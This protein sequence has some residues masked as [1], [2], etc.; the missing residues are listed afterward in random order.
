MPTRKRHQYENENIMGEQ[1]VS[2]LADKEDMQQ[3]VR[4]LL[5]DV[6]ALDYMLKNDWFESDIIRIGAEQ[7]MCLVDSR[8]F[9]PA[10]IA[11]EALAKMQDLPWV[12]TELAR[13]NLETGATPVQFTGDCLNVMEQQIS[14]QLATIQERI[15]D[16]GADIILTGI[17]PTLQ[18]FDMGM[19]NLTPVPRYFALMKA[20]NQ[21]L[22]KRST[23]EVRLQGVD[24]LI[25]EH[26]SPLIE[27]CN[28]SFQVHLQVPPKKFVQM[29]N[30]A[31][32]ITAPVMAISANSPIVF[33]KRLW[34]ESRIALFQQAL[35]TRS[36]SDHMRER[37]PRV[38]FGNDWLHDSMIEIYKEDI[39]RFRVLISGD[40]KE[41]SF[42]LIKQGKVP[43]LRALQVHNSTVYRW[44]R[45]CYGISENG[46]PHL[47]IENRVF[48]AGP[49]IQDE[50]ANAAFW[51]GLMMAFAEEYED[52][53]Q[54]ISFE[55]AKDNFGKAAK[56]GIDTK[57]TWLNDE[58]ISA[59]LLVQQ[60]LLP[61]ARKGLEMMKVSPKDIDKYLGII[62]ARA[63]NHVNGA[64]WMLRAYT[65]LKQKTSDNE[66]LTALTA[67]IIQ[68]QKSGSPVH[69]WGM[70]NTNILKK[71][72]P[73]KFRVEEFMV[74]DLF[75]VEPDDIIEMVADLMDWRKLR[76]IPVES[77]EGELV[78]L[79]S[80]RLLMRHFT[81]EKK[82]Q[83]GEKPAM[84]VKDIMIKHPITA[85]PDTTLMD[86]LELMQHHRIGSLPVVRNKELLGMITEKEFLQITGRLMRRL[87]EEEND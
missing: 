74:K 23:Y 50:M 69:E 5:K 49:T 64:R 14:S 13:F 6:E 32:A 17:L 22:K 87:E 42:E 12:E 33:G 58:K 62:E 45:P 29:Y 9:K 78:G 40:V 55:D 85:S 72:R 66:A 24:E 31:L 11:Q 8:T 59:V 10:S 1:R 81:S 47:R 80:S 53:T 51:L 28:T 37:S 54:L 65:Q 18:K 57:F 44:N 43:K 46:K 48:A 60:Q 52:I 27:A 19:H 75:T 71:Y 83:L 39:A 79:V 15:K 4:S 3:F 36:T 25:I 38:N 82:G 86:A 63:L 26:D 56:Y 61:R 34:H 21:Q 73:S 30:I 41:D 76:Y 70:P 16:M 35:D 77:H 68:N 20:I 2:L 7:E 84:L 67:A